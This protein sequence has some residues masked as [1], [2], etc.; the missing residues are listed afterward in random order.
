MDQLRV[1]PK[2]ASQRCFEQWK[3]SWE[4]CVAAREDYF[5]RALGTIIVSE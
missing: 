5:E 3:N 4:K 2:E 1:I